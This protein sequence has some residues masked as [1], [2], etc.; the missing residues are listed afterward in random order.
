M[1]RPR[2]GRRSPKDATPAVG[3]HRLGGRRLPRSSAAIDRLTTTPPQRTS[4]PRVLYV[5][6]APRPRGG[7][8]EEPPGAARGHPARGGATRATLAHSAPRSGCAPATPMPASA[9]RSLTRPPDILITTPESLYLMLTSSGPRRR[10]ASVRTVIV[11]EIH[12]IAATKRGAHLMLS[13][14]RLEALTDDAA[15]ADRAVRHAASA[16]GDRATP[17]RLRAPD[18]LRDVAVVDA[19]RRKTARPG[20]H[21]SRSTTWPISASGRSRHPHAQLTDEPDHLDLA[22]DPSRCCSI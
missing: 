17:R 13:L 9:R 8:R 11:D 21:R 16:G 4:A 1:P 2:A 20:D 18:R 15:P 12:A 14:E 19:G 5:L 6:A 7:H 22:F 10:C 3:A